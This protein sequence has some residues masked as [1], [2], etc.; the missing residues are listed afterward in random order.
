MTEQERLTDIINVTLKKLGVDRE[1]SW[2]GDKYIIPLKDSN[3]FSKLYT[4]LDKFEEADLDFESMLMSDSSG[5]L[6]YLTD[7]L[8]ITLKANFDDDKYMLIFE[9]A[10][11]D[12]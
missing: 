4:S 6:V 8:D 2:N 5:I 11:V 1:G 10:D 7:D 12:A 9:G 3:E